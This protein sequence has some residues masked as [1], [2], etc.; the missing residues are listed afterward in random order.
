[1][2][3]FNIYEHGWQNTPDPQWKQH[4]D[5]GPEERDE[6]D[7]DPDEAYERAVQ[8]ELDANR[9]AYHA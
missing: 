2:G 4:G 5:G 9:V 8:E 6:R 7:P 1:M 3:R